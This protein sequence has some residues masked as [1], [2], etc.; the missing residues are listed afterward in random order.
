MELF[1]AFL[2]RLSGF[3]TG[4]LDP[5]RLN[6]ACAALEVLDR[7]RAERSAAGQALD[8]ALSNERLSG[9]PAF[10]DPEERR[11]L[12]ALLR[13][14]RER[15][16]GDGELVTAELEEIGRVFPG[17]AARSEALSAA[18]RREREAEEAYAAAHAADL[19]QAREALSTLFSDPALCE[20]VLLQSGEAF[21]RLSGLQRAPG[22]RDARAR[23]RERVAALYAQ[24]F[25]AKNDTNSLCGPHAVVFLADVE[26]DPVQ[27]RAGGLT[28]RRSYFSHWAAE[29]LLAAWAARC[30]APP[31]TRR[32]PLSRREGD[33]VTFCR[34]ELSLPGG[35]KRRHGRARVPPELWRELESGGPSS[36]ELEAAVEAGLALQ[37][38]RLPVGSFR[39]LDD[40]GR[41]LAAFPPGPA[42]DEAAAQLAELRDQLDRFERGDLA[43]RVEATAAL[44]AAFE[45]AA[46]GPAVRGHA[47]HYADRWLV[48]EDCLAQ[49]EVA[50]GEG[51][52]RRI[53][54]ALEPLLS[55]CALPMER[56]REATRAWFAARFG[57]RRRVPALEVLRGFD[58]EAP[59][60]A[61][62]VTPLGQAIEAASAR[63]QRL[64]AG[65]AAD[66][67]GR[68]DPRALREASAVPGLRARPGFASADLLLGRREG[69]PPLLV[70]GELHG[71]FC[72]PT[73]LLDV[74]PP[75]ERD[76]LLES[77]RA[78]L[79]RVAGGRRT[80]E[81]VLLHLDATAR[82]FPVADAD[83]ELVGYTGHPES[84]RLGELDLVLEE[85]ELMFLDGDREVVPAAIYENVPFL[86]YT[87]RLGPL[88]DHYQSRYFPEALLPEAL[89]DAAPRL[90][91]GDDVVVR[92]ACRRV[93]VSSAR[94]ALEA[95]TDGARFAA[96]R[97]WVAALG[98]GD[99]FFASV[100]GE[101]KPLMVDARN[102]F[103]LEALLHVLERAPGE[104][105]ANLSEMVPAP[106]ELLLEGPDGPRTSELRLGV[107]R[108]P[109]EGTADA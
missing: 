57:E 11:R 58:Q 40:A 16:R 71:F 66:Q 108:A 99:R 72:F 65:A 101:P 35:W 39:P 12:R 62:P 41:A 63:V 98:M 86:E 5:L 59:A 103:L 27:L 76:R 87:S 91:L 49:V 10:D 94:E 26:R 61:S 75:L 53:A 77:M 14:T 70:V 52:R 82:R 2:L 6:R 105:T 95:T 3:S 64:I 84:H 18:A 37:E 1:S 15:A 7:A 107:L 56:A 109:L 80:A 47:Q 43:A 89:R 32:N 60:R 93:P 54:A 90:T 73:C 9:N 81:P 31:S 36:G 22:P 106:E 48:H 24:R 38:P 50:L 79:R 45:R 68:L 83:L 85:G 88:Y 96:A 44:D 28:H 74:V 4:R 17:C 19:E 34:M 25:C 51:A 97:R 13:R 92:R 30:G 102:P 42:R 46:A 100:S 69:A 55:A 33:Q 67:G 78:A 29:A 21:R 23:Q 8:A 20:A 104:G